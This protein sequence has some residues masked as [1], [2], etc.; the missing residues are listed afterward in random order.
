[1]VIPKIRTNEELKPLAQLIREFGPF[2]SMEEVKK[3]I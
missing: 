3:D 1:M 2:K